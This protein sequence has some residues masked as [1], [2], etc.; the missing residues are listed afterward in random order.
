MRDSGV[1]PTTTS[2]RYRVILVRPDR[3]VG[4][5]ESGD[6]LKYRC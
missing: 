6:E 2:V 1:F 5:Y 3:I 4:G